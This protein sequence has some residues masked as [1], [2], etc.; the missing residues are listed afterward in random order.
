MSWQVTAKV[1]GGYKY[2]T[3]ETETYLR[4]AKAL[5]HAA[6]ELNRT[7]DS[8]R[9]LSFQLSTYPYASSTIALLSGS[10]SYCN[11]ADH[12]ELP[13][14]QLIERCDSH[15]NALG[16]MAARLSELSALIIRAQSLYSHVDDAGR[17]ALNELLQLTITAFPKESILIGTAMS[18]LGYVMGSINEGK[19]NPIYLLDSLDWAQEG[20]MGAAGAALSGYSKV[21]S[22]LHTDEVNHAAG[23]ISKAS[24]RGYNL[25][26]GNNL[27]VTRVRPKTEVVRESHSVGEALEDL[28]RLGEERLGKADLDSGLE[29]GTIAISKYRRT[30]GTDSWLVTIPGTD[31]KRNSPFGWPQNV[32]LM[33][34]DSKQRMEADSARMVQEAMKQAGINSDEPVALIG[35][36]QGG[37]VA[38]TIAS[39]LKDDY[40]I[41]HVVTAGSP[42]ANH[43]IPNKTWVTSVE[44]DDE[45]VAALD[46][47]PNPNSEHWLTVRGTASKSD[48]NPESTFAGTPVTDA[49]DNKEITH[50]LKY[51]QAAYQNAT[52]M[53]S[54]AVK[55]HE[56]HFDEILD[57]D[58]QEVMYFEGRMSK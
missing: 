50:W 25:I 19:S 56:R 45:L 51:H 18:A 23:T 47:A 39:D 40:D 3:E 6:D 20:I 36:S 48:N 32:E 12:I 9:A 41:K 28:R 13:Y 37:I 11:A 52:D 57:G 8:F 1:S 17:R 2:S 7:H 31:G 33:S 53:G 14:D 16:A 30:D 44:M 49:P 24:S 26:Q 10:N 54:S 5:S 42:V 58:L 46:G 43:P 34:S 21:T 38:A 29:Y 55:T 4:A 22:L 15:A 27:T 35:H